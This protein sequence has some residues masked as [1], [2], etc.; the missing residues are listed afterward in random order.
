[1]NEHSTNK[2]KMY[3]LHA[4]TLD[5]MIEILKS[6]TI[7]LGNVV[8]GSQFGSNCDCI[9]LSAY[10]DDIKN[11]KMTYQMTLLLKP[12]I[13]Y[14]YKLSFGK[15][16]GYQPNYVI[17]KKNDKQLDIKLK[18]IRTYLKDPDLPPVLKGLGVLEH[19]LMIQE[20]I[21][22]NKYLAGIILFCV[23]DQKNKVIKVLSD[24]KIKTK[25]YTTNKPP[26]Y[27]DLFDKS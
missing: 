23:K 14:D 18:K 11:I 21:P 20:E 19:E 5:G 1:M 6:G 26:K 8:S 9:F 13:I 27:N 10:F 7:K 4:T 3:F 17:I 24:Q 16:W 25:I 22:L 12:E 15:G 2:Y